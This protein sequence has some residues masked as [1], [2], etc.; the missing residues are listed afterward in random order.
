M[1]VY[2]HEAIRIH[3]QPFLQPFFPAG[4]GLAFL[5]AMFYGRM[6]FV[7]P[8]LVASYDTQGYGTPILTG[9]YT[10]ISTLVLISPTSEG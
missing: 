1:R 9:A 7:T 8:T 6:P 4:Q 3:I 5:E 2:Q 10:G